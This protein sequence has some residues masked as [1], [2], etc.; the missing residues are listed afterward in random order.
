MNEQFEERRL[1][2]KVEF[3]S[4]AACNS[5]YVGGDMK[6]WWLDEDHEKKYVSSLIVSTLDADEGWDEFESF[7]EHYDA[8]PVVIHEGQYYAA[9]SAGKPAWETGVS[10]EDAGEGLTSIGE[11][12]SALNLEPW[13]LAA[14]YGWPSSSWPL[15]AYETIPK[16]ARAIR[17]YEKR[18]EEELEEAR[19]EARSEREERETFEREEREDRAAE[20]GEKLYYA[21]RGMT[22]EQAADL[23][24]MPN[25]SR[26]VD[27][28]VRG[29]IDTATAL[30]RAARIRHRHEKTDYDALLRAGWRKEDAR[31]IIEDI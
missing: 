19:K 5:V 25:D 11:L 18:R 12:A 27:Q 3:R 1:R 21:P 28:Y 30:R 24:D 22:R 31:A 20:R 4:F 2:M 29:V 8:V 17:R 14:D 13:S 26:T 10:V 6:D 9:T 23:L 7:S 16:V 15:S